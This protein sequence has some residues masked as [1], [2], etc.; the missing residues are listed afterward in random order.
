MNCTCGMIECVCST[1]KVHAEDCRFRKALLCPVSI[2]CEH[3]WDVCPK[4]DPCTCRPEP[5]DLE[6]LAA[7][8]FATPRLESVDHLLTPAAPGKVVDRG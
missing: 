5:Q 8:L 7:V 1:A 4:C 6:G 2:E 3:G